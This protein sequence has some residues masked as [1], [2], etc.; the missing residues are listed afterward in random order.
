MPR[1]L[2]ELSFALPRQERG[3]TQEQLAEIGGLD[4]T[5]ASLLERALRT[6]TLS[7]LFRLADALGLEAAQLV[8][9]TD[10]VIRKPSRYVTVPA[11]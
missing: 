8:K 6:P 3:L 2:S 7:V 5:Y 11:E 9:T 10:S 1:L 4:R